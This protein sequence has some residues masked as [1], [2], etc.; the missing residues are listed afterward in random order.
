MPAGIGADTHMSAEQHPPPGHCEPDAT[1]APTTDFEAAFGGLS[2]IAYRVAY[3]ILGSQAEAEDVS[4]EALARAYLRWRRVR[5]HA[6]PWVAHVA[7]NLAIDTVRRRRTPPATVEPDGDVH[8]TALDRLVLV[9]LLRT[10]PKRQREV[11]VLRYLAD[12]SEAATARALG[13]SIG[14]VKRHANRALTTLR[15]RMPDASEKGTDD[16]RPA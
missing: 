14:S 13:C 3:R 16:V 1:E 11:L 6:E 10:L 15:A 4:Q 7:G 8:R 12:Q 2:I 9:E 5:D